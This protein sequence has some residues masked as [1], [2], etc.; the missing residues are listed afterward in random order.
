MEK[1]IDIVKA[2]SYFEEYSKWLS[3]QQKPD[4]E[5]LQGIYSQKLIEIKTGEVDMAG[6]LWPKLDDNQIY[7]G[8]YWENRIIGATDANIAK[9]NEMRTLHMGLDFF[10]PAK[11]PIYL[12]LMGKV[13]SFKNNDNP[14]DYGP[15]IIIEHEA[16][17]GKFYSLYGH[18]DLSSLNG[19]QKGQKI[20]LGDKIGNLGDKKENGG[21]PP[22]LHFQ[23]ILDI[24]NKEGDFDGLCR[25]I[26]ANYWQYI[27][28]SPYDFLGL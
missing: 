9:D 4:I 10:A 26:D 22:H 13:H 5:I 23:L 25:P 19:L 28:P 1:I 11:T 21:W 6:P 16:T 20:N 3:Q 7:I 12:P 18:L 15:C 27:C 24:K 8:G 17:F 14:R 2:K